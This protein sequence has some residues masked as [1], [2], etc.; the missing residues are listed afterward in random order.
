MVISFFLFSF[1]FSKASNVTSF[2]THLLLVCIHVC[3]YPNLLVVHISENSILTFSCISASFQLFYPFSSSSLLIFSKL[4]VI[5]LYV[6]PP[7]FPSHTFF[8][9]LG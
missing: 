6:F 2:S 9:R 7:S 4:C 3:T 5:S 8:A 1:T